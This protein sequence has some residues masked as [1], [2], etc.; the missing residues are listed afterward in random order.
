MKTILPFSVQLLLIV[1]SCQGHLFAQS[2]LEVKFQ[3]TE[4][5]YVYETKGIGT[6]GDLYSAVIQNIAIV[7]HA[8]DSVSIEEIEIIAT[9]GDVEIQRFKVPE[10]ILLQSAEKF[11]TYQEQGILQ[12]YD[13]QFQTSKYLKG[14]TFSRN[15]TLAK[16][17][18]VVITHRTLLF[19]TLPDLVTVRV[20]AG[21]SNG[22]YLL[23]EAALKVV[24]HVSKNQYD[25]PL[26]GTW[27][28]Y[29]APSLISHHRWGSIQ[30]FA[31]DFVKIGTNGTT[32]SGTGS[33]LTDYY[34]YGEPIYAI[35]SG[36]IVSI[37]DGA[38]ESNENL[39]Q[40]NET[41]EEYLE[42][43]AVLQQK[44]LAKGF[45][46]VMGNHIIIE[47]ENGEYSHYLHLQNGSLKV[48][49]GDYVKIGDQI[50]ALGHSGNSTEPHLHFH[51]TDGPDMA[52]SRSIPVS[53]DN[54]SLYPDDNKN[55]RHIHYG[56][57][58]VTN[59]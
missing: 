57:I 17:E 45:S 14:I 33:K 19:Q 44:L 32:H 29:G 35:G 11:K 3:P 21:D 26:K 41:A 12:Y 22:N 59:D 38:T 46:Y 51:V 9:Q 1:F 20:K 23:G 37:Y 28:A 5:M 49:E 55:I 36:K 16:E 47:H 39:K 2:S 13:F 58:I 42:R 34:A 15:P 52:Y 50:A 18:A 56:Q 30:E 25:F 48:K 53:F 24:N 40:Q 4:Y 10:E 7:N 31:Y 27:A 8:E 6:P 43:S 54:I